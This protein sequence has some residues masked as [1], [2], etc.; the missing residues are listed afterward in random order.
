[1]PIATSGAWLVAG[2]LADPGQLAASS[3][4]VTAII[5]REPSGTV[6]HGVMGCDAA[7]GGIEKNIVGPGRAAIAAMAW[8]AVGD[9]HAT[10]RIAWLVGAIRQPQVGRTYDAAPM[11]I[12]YKSDFFLQLH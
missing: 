4:L 10:A 7:V 3:P 8:T 12:S 6:N 5:V 2:G 9:D 11:Y 1:M